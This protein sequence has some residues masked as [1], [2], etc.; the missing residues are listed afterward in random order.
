MLLYDLSAS[1]NPD[2]QISKANIGSIWTTSTMMNATSIRN[3]TFFQF[4]DKLF[5]VNELMCA[6]FAR[7]KVTL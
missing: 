4:R 5:K 6:T 3:I 2:F 1:S 7:S